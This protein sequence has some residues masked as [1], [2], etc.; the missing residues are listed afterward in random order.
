MTPHK[1]THLS[2]ASISRLRNVSNTAD[3]SSFHF[4]NSFRRSFLVWGCYR[5]DLITDYYLF[6]K[7]FFQQLLP[8]FLRQLGKLFFRLECKKMTY[9]F[10]S[11]F[12][13]L[14]IHRAQVFR[15]LSVT[16]QMI[17]RRGASTLSAP[18]PPSFI[19]TAVPVWLE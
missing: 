1:P 4:F 6:L 11:L 9:I 14:V 18:A 8:L 16:Q 7:P 17:T 19:N 13:T 12:A 2:I 15:Y 3:F 5:G 10:H